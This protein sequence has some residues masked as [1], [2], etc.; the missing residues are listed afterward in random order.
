M[1]YFSLL[2]SIKQAY[3]LIHALLQ[4]IF[5][6]AFAPLRKDFIC[7]NGLTRQT[8]ASMRS[9]RKINAYSKLIMGQFNNVTLLFAL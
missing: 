4:K 7:I 1:I 2:I 5:R 3:R 6:L 9:T 8:I